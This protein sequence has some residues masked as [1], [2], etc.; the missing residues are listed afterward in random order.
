MLDRKD[1]LV[2]R[3]IY[4]RVEM[5]ISFLGSDYFWRPQAKIQRSVLTQFLLQTLYARKKKVLTFPQYTIKRSRTSAKD[6]KWEK[7]APEQV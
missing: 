2:E 7:T 6:L 4:I 1:L 5:S 3:S